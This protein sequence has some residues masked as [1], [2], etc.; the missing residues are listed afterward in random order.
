MSNFY[1][2]T[3]KETDGFELERGV[4]A[5]LGEPINDGDDLQDSP[6]DPHSLAVLDR[7][8]DAAKLFLCPSFGPFFPSRF[9]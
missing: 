4:N 5:V 8:V 7:E 3:K 6:T 1:L 9:C 2:I